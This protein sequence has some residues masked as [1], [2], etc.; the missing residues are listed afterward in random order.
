[1]NKTRTVLVVLSIAVGVFAIGVIMHARLVLASSL[2]ATYEATDP[3]HATFY[4][5]ASFPASLAESV[6]HVDGVE[7]AEAR[8]SVVV[9]LRRG[10][11][12]GLISNCRLCLILMIFGC[13]VCVRRVVCG[14]RRIMIL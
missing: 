14:R 4:T 1:M 5:L 3:A 2:A 13:L 9:R 8:R 12:S 6:R 7:E 10:M 11:M